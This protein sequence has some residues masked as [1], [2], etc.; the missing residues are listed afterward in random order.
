[1]REK[2]HSHECHIGWFYEYFHAVSGVIRKKSTVNI[3]TTMSAEQMTACA[4]NRI[5]FV[6]IFIMKHCQ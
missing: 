2:R 5:S 3:Y 6:S 1:M 4:N